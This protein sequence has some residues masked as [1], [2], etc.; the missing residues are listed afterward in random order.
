M[1][2]LAVVA[3]P[4]D[5]ILGC[6]ATLKKLADEGNQVYSCVLCSA[7]DAR[8]NRP[9]LE[10]LASVSRTAS[11]LVGISDS[12][13]YEFPNIQFNTV[14]HL[15]MV[16]AVEA[17]ILRFKPEWIFTHHPGDINIDHRV[18]FETTMAAVMLPQRLSSDLKPTMIS[19]VF[20]FEILSSTDW[21]PPVGDG[22]RPNS[23]FEVSA[24]FASKLNALDAFE[25]ALKPF[26]HSR[27]RENVRNLASLRGAQV[28]LELAEAFSLIR[29]VNL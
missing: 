25:G 14:P 7:V 10:R 5:E 17:A 21:A 4:D 12:I 23:F 22:F 16:K 2:V 24:T 8:H 20:L 18:C 3:H 13:A 1:N 26:P 29:D 19:R 27:S 6:G 9:S 28:G 15:E 11:S